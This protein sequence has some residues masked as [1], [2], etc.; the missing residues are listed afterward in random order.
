MA[1]VA[2][3]DQVANAM[4]SPR[5]GQLVVRT[6]RQCD[7]FAAYGTARRADESPVMRSPRTGQLVVGEQSEMCTIEQ[8]A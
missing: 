6:S 2:A 7:A 5:T 1:Q 8:S 4:S 3:R